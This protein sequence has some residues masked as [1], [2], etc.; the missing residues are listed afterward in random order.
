M[1]MVSFPVDLADPASRAFAARQVIQFFQ[2]GG[3]ITWADFQRMSEA[4][5]ELF[6]E[7]RNRVRAAERIIEG[8]LTAPANAP[9]DPT[10]SNPREP[11]L[12]ERAMARQAVEFA[13]REA[14]DL[15]P[16]VPVAEMEA[17]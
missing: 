6:V 12:V 11:S 9:V 16:P 10:I 1:S 8:E 17:P 3:S 5:R 4:E 14:V 15:S 13:E 7:I 2:M